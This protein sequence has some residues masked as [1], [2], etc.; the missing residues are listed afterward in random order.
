MHLLNSDGEEVGLD[1]VSSQCPSV[2]SKL[3]LILVSIG[4]IK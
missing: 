3:L 4:I 2:S 1:S